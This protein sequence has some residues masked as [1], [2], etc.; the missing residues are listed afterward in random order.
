MC[1]G[2]QRLGFHFGNP[3][4]GG[5]CA[6][7]AQGCRSNQSNG[8]QWSRNSMVKRLTDP[9]KQVS[10]L[11]R[12]L[13]KGAV[14]LAGPRAVGWCDRRLTEGLARCRRQSDAV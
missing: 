1:S 10:G 7:L 8:Q 5:A 6:W 14:G 4:R 3:L 2:V 11:G 12:G 13:I 9:V